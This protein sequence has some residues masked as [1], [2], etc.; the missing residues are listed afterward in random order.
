MGDYNQMAGCFELHVPE[1]SVYL[2][3]IVPP[4]VK[5]EFESWL[6]ASA[7]RNLFE[8]RPGG[9][10]PKDQQLEPDEYQESLQASVE[11]SG[12][13]TFRWGGAACL[14][15]FQQIPGMM[16]MVILL[17]RSADRVMRIDQKLTEE[18][19]LGWIDNTAERGGPVWQGVIAA[20]KQ[21]LSSTPNFLAPPTRGTTQD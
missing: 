14:K 10:A 20:I 17:S 16:Q 6:E 12:A 1:G 18:R 2:R 21:I 3:A 4:R 9:P 7:R 19:I 5:G 11:A 8:L 13:G 15:A